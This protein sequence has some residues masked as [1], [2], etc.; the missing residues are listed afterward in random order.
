MDKA[1]NDTK[2]KKFS[3]FLMNYL[4]MS[5][6]YCTFAASKVKGNTQ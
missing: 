3:E 4:H 5:E 2:K 6:I 1:K